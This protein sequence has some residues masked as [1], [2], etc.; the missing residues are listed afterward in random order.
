MIDTYLTQYISGSTLHGRTTKLC[1]EYHCGH[2]SVPQS[3]Q[4]NYGY[5]F[6]K[7]RRR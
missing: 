6:L 5:R 1:A 3:L 4:W 7:I 2:L